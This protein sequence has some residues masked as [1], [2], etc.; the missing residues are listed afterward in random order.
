[1]ARKKTTKGQEVGLDKAETIDA[2][3]LE[4]L[5]SDAEGVMEADG[6]Q[7]SPKAVGLKPHLYLTPM[8]LGGL[9]AGAIGFGI[10][11]L[12]DY[13][14]SNDQLGSLLLDQKE[15]HDQIIS[16]SETVS[17]LTNIG[18]PA[19][20]SEELDPFRISLSKLSAV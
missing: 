11:I 8:F 15:I 5:P 19:N 10:A 7:A 1:M 17:E 3:V 2:E 13:F 12:P 9:C 16:L 14:N 6:G 20:F 4:T 18:P